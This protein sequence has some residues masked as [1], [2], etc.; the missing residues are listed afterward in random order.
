MGEGQRRSIY[1]ILV[2]VTNTCGTVLN[3]MYG[4]LTVCR[5]RDL[6]ATPTFTSST[7]SLRQ[8][9]ARAIRP[10]TRHLSRS[11]PRKRPASRQS[12]TSNSQ[13][14]GDCNAAEAGRLVDDRRWPRQNS[15]YESIDGLCKQDTNSEGQLSTAGGWCSLRSKLHAMQA[16]PALRYRVRV[17]DKGGPH[18]VSR[19]D[20]RCQ[21]RSLPTGLDA[22]CPRRPLGSLASF[23]I[24]KDAK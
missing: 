4:R 12:H 10:I 14:T 16:G 17:F 8:P 6:S 21:P 24:L 11:E 7:C 15:A 3:A 19:P 2:T 9:P 20:E 5:P 13:S 22:A 23:Y 18:H 1:I